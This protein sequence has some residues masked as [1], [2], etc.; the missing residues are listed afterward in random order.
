LNPTLN[1]QAG[2]IADL[3][4]RPL[5]N[6]VS[7]VERIVRQLISIHKE[8][9]DANETSW[10]FQR[11]ILLCH[12]GKSH[13]IQES[14]ASATDHQIG[15]VRVAKSLE[16]ANNEVFISAYGL[17]GEI[18]PDVD[19]AEITLRIGSS[20][21]FIVA[22]ISY[23]IG[24]MM[25]RYSLDTPGLIYA[26]SGNEGFDSSKYKKFPADSDGII[27]LMDHS[28]FEDDATAR[29]IS[30]LKVA[31]SEETLAENLKFVADSLEPKSGET[32]EETIQRYFS[33]SFFKDHLKTYKKRPIYW[34]F[35]SG[36]EGAFQALVYLHRYNEGTLSR[37][38]TDYVLPLQSK[39]S[40]EERRLEM[41][42]ETA[43]SPAERNRQ[44]KALQKLNK[45]S[46]ELRAFDEKLHHLADQRIKLDLD[47]GV[48]VNYAKLAPLLAGVKEVTGGAED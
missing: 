13:L 45:K 33:D 22:L 37:M 32:P 6:A 23:A 16:E 24:C 3:P 18:L 1:F 39:H 21:D 9:W 20:V 44:K 4:I 43:S 31:W 15:Q 42:I 7:I 28:W 5:H 26:N 34:L 29:F 8:D 48:K 25:G 12:E 19:T 46:V 40:N 17:T 14:L 30:F 47:D 2:N 27:P 10:D 36:K 11:D 41:L 38:R 35:T